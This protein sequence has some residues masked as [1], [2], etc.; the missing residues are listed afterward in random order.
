M[1]VLRVW[2]LKQLIVGFS[3]SFTVKVKLQVA[4]LLDPSVTVQ[5]TVVIPLLN[6]P[7]VR[8]AEP[9]PAVTPLNTYAVVE[10][11]QLSLKA[12][13]LNSVPTAV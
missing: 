13:G 3:L 12:V 4:L 11:G 6:T 7:P 2:L 9:L 1:L 8:V 5:I 10:P